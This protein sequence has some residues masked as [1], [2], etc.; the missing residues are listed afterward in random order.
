MTNIVVLKIKDDIGNS[1]PADQIKGMKK[2]G[3]WINDYLA[4]PGKAK[5]VMFK[6]LYRQLVENDGKYQIA[7]KDST[8]TLQEL[9]PWENSKGVKKYRKFTTVGGDVYKIVPKVDAKDT[10]DFILMHIAIP[11]TTQDLLQDG[12]IGNVVGD[13]E[14]IYNGPGGDIEKT[15]AVKKYLLATV[16][17]SRCH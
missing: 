13:I 3:Q 5:R 9:S 16:F 12:Y 10:D 4:L 15:T 14:D 8:G 17:L 7:V 2:A 11:A 6:R 1:I